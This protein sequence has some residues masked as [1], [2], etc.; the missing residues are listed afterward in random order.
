MATF[1]YDLGGACEKLIAQAKDFA[2]QNYAGP[3]GLGRANGTLD[4]LTSPMNGGVKAELVSSNGG[5]KVRRARVFYKQRVQP[6]EIMSGASGLAATLCDTPEE[7]DEKEVLVDVSGRVANTPFKISDAKMVVICQD[8]KAW[9]DEFLSS[10]MR[11]GRE[12]LNELS[13]ALVAANIGKNIHQDGSTPTAAGAY[14]SKDIL[15][16][17][18]NSQ[19]I[20]LIGNWNDTLMDYQ[21]MQFTG[22]PAFIGQGNLQTFIKLAKMS[23]CNSSNISFQM[24]IEGA[25]AAYFLDQSANAVLDANKALML[26]FGASHLLTFNENNNININSETV[27]H[28]VVQD[29]V[30]PSLKW[31]LDFKWDECAKAWI[32]QISVYHDIF[33]V[34]QAD[35]FNNDDDSPDN[36]PACSDELLGVTGI[37]GYDFTNS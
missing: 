10:Y 22:V 25:N 36:S 23:C 1:D 24:A 20:P 13:L 9:Y 26:S 8:T 5:R 4:F 35:S 19:K 6:C 12:K 30:Y 37:W 17:D 7:R 2:K 28:I 27:K 32:F 11:A 31:D 34:F 18:A 3:G 21:N 33:N 29:P 16:V 14:K 15:G